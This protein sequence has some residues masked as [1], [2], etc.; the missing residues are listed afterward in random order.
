MSAPCPFAVL[1][2]PVTATAREVERAATK[3]L[4]M[5]A[6]GLADAA[7]YLG[8][9]GPQPR[10]PEAV[11]AAAATLRDPRQRLAA[12]LFAAAPGSVPSPPPA[13]PPADRWDGALAA[14]AWAPAEPRS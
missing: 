4:G 6:L 12:E 9:D 13:P 14:L 1:E 11:R 3:L 8:P 2:L 5:L 7:T 10:T